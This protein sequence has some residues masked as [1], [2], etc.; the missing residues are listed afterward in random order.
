MGRQ[1]TG[2][3]GPS[4]V[5]DTGNA[6]DSSE[7]VSFTIDTEAPTDP[8]DLEG[9]SDGSL[10]GDTFFTPDSTPEF[11]WVRSTD[12]I[13]VISYEAVITSGGTPT[14]TK[15][16]SDDTACDDITGLCVVEMPNVADNG[17][18]VVAVTAL[19]AAGNSSVGA[20]SLDFF[21]DDLP[22]DPPGTPA[23][24]L[25]TISSGDLRS[26][27]ISWVAAEDPG[28]PVTGSGID[29]YNIVVNPGGFSGVSDTTTFFTP[30]LT[31]G[32]YTFSVSAVDLATNE[33]A[34][35]DSALT[36][37]G[38]ADKVRNLI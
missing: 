1:V 31:P 28:E 26:V 4:L 29:F 33:G 8:T 37:V 10:V 25:T 15:V 24:T 7:P 12:N 35:A 2:A 36:P 23:P 17:P 20:A 32:D 3:T 16:V 27:E 9:L 21:F 18:Y 19:D 22:P 30:F 14:V 34:F 5:T 11:Q 13:E 38:P 6:S